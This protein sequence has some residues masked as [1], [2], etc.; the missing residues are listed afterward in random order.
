MPLLKKRQRAGA[1]QDAGASQDAKDKAECL[2]CARGTSNAEL[3]TSETA[4]LSM[5]GRLMLVI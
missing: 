4:V 5:M 2:E 1:V 3:R